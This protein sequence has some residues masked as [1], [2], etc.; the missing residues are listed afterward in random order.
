MRKSLVRSITGIFLTFAIILSMSTLC[1][2]DGG[3]LTLN[4]S[5]KI[6]EVGEKFRVVIEINASASGIMNFGPLELS[7]DSALFT[8]N[9][10][11][12]FPTN[13]GNFSVNGNIAGKVIMSYSPNDGISALPISGVTNLVGIYFTPKVA[14]S[15]TFSITQ[16]EGFSDQSMG[17]LDFAPGAT[18]TVDIIVPVPKSDNNNLK[19]LNVD[20]GT[21]SPA[22][23]AGTLKYSMQVAEGLSK[24]SVSAAP[25]DAKASVTITGHTKLVDGANTIKITVT[26]ENGSK[27][28]YTI[29]ATRAGPTPTPV[30]TPTPAVTLTLPGG[31]YTVLD[32]PPDMVPPAGF[33][34]STFTLNAQTVQIY[35][36]AQGDLNLFYLAAADDTPGLFYY[37]KSTDSY[38]PFVVMTIPAQLFTVLTPDS[39]VTVP[40]GFFETTLLL[41]GQSVIAWQRTTVTVTPVPT[42]TT[43]AGTTTAATTSQ[44]MSTETT[45]TLSTIETTST[46][47]T[48]SGEYLLY[49][50]DSSGAKNFYLYNAATMALSQY[51]AAETIESTETTAGSEATEATETT[52]SGVNPIGGDFNIWQLFSLALGLICLVLIGMVIWLV[53]RGPGGVRK[54]KLPP[55]K[56]PSIRRVD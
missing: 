55:E 10:A 15:S 48:A 50:M 1:Q 31:L 44:T 35:Q 53:V 34:L 25:A 22:F 40:A 29:I 41:N 43:T 12:L 26:A 6:Y 3:A 36:S 20:P 52:A 27:K 4:T 56:K 39:G 7:Y 46:A 18:K 47:V 49:L 9:E 51:Q 8:F 19:S 32:L 30:A 5:K 45:D 38:L 37:N 11:V 23:A 2:A 42:S 14:G 33:T 13:P 16:S 24:I 17:T 21:L 54:E 28:T